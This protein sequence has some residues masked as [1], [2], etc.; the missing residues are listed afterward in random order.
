[1][2]R[3]NGTAVDAQGHPSGAYAS[4]SVELGRLV[5][6]SGREMDNGAIAVV[7]NYILF[8][9]GDASILESDQ[10]VID[11]ITYD[12]RLVRNPSGLSHHLEVD[13]ERLN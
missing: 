2:R 5:V 8:L 1:M 12:V 4:T 10:V 13:L 11:N 6:R 7:S 9:G 3:A